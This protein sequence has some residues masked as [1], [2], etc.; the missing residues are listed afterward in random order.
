MKVPIICLLHEERVGYM[1]HGTCCICD[2]K[3]YISV[4]GIPGEITL[5]QIKEL[6]VKPKYIGRECM[7]DMIY[8]F[9]K[10]MKQSP[11]IREVAKQRLL[12]HEYGIKK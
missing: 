10:L 2:E 3:T 9:E 6:P 5:D 1:P 7:I 4:R 11:E 8:V 12:E